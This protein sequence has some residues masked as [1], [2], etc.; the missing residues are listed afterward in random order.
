MTNTSTS[1]WT[2]LGQIQPHTDNPSCSLCAC[3]LSDW[4]SDS[5]N[6]VINHMERKHVCNLHVGQQ[7]QFGIINQWAW[8][9]PACSRLAYSRTELT[10]TSYDGYFIN[11]ILLMFLTV[12]FFGKL[13]SIDQ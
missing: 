9:H 4:R 2:P 8:P 11:N 3:K 1:A 10:C 12:I 7:G 13:V 5:K 6:V